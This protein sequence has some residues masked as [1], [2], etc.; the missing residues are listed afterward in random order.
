MCSAAD[1]GLIG[2]SVARVVEEGHRGLGEVAAGDGPL[3]VL[4]REHGADEADDR[5]A[6]R[7]DLNRP[8]S[9]GGSNL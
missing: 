1:C 8:G 9:G 6:V 4:L 7:E 2:V 5:F 3:V